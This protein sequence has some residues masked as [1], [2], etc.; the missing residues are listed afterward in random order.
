M[1]G[2]NVMTLAGHWYSG[3]HKRS[4]AHSSLLSKPQLFS[5]AW[6]TFKM[7]LPTWQAGSNQYEIEG[8]QKGT[9]CPYASRGCKVTG[10]Q[11]FNVSKKPKF[12]FTD[13]INQHVVGNNE[14]W[15]GSGPR[16]Q[17]HGVQNCV[18]SARHQGVQERIGFQKYVGLNKIDAWNVFAD[19]LSHGYF[20]DFIEL[21]SS[22]GGWW[23]IILVPVPITCKIMNI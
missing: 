3:A 20:A 14:S 19:D 4:D 18:P 16:V 13:G 7:L 6:W 9:T 5:M 8:F 2:P 22:K 1:I 23:N 15:T 12:L 11:S 17:I 21:F 10:R